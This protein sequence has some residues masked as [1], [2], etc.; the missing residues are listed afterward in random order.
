LL[1]ELEALEALMSAPAEQGLH[2]DHKP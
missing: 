1:N 2:P